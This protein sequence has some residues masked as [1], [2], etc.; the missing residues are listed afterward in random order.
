MRKK[1]DIGFSAI[2]GGDIAG[3]HTVIFF[4]KN[5]RIELTHKANDRVIFARGALK[6]AQFI[7]DKSDQTN[8]NGYFTM[9]DVLG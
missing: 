1:G 7:S 3:E 4:G 6:A 8:F 5:E 9:D 2:R